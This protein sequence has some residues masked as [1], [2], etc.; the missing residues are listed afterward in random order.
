MTVTS[1]APGNRADNGQPGFAVG[2]RAAGVVVMKGYLTS[3]QGSMGNVG[4]LDFDG[5]TP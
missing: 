3:G 2:R 5:V 1:A 4:D